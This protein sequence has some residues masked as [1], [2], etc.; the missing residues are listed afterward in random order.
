MILK[1]QPVAQSIQK[2]IAEFLEKNKQAKRP[3][4][5]AVILAGDFAPSHTYVKK[6]LEACE[7]V[8][9]QGKLLS[10][11]AS[12]TEKELLETIDRLNK[13]PNVDGI[14]VQLPLPPHLSSE[15]ILS[16]MDPEKDVDGLHPVNAGKLLLGN[17]SGFIPCTPLGIVTL[18]DHYGIAI[19]GKRALVI[20]RSNI[21]GKPLAI[22]L[23]SQG[24]N[25]NATVTLAH[26]KTARLK[27]L[28]REHELVIV[29][30][31]KPHFVTKEM[32]SKDMVIVDVGI[33]KIQLPSGK[34]KLVGDVHYEEVAPL[35]KAITPVPGGVGPMTIASVLQNTLIS[36]K[37]RL[38]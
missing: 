22:L 14:L 12:V 16:R 33:N 26:S 38:F 21:V 32:V 31:G 4:C 36:Y 30:I 8:G 9:I 1:G 25:R 34:S 11:D 23:G 3:P 37:R 7:H 13:D 29:A 28:C 27:E 35:V 19:E 2:A 20:G 15:K 6:K 17:H 10:F 18:L 24:V 5:L